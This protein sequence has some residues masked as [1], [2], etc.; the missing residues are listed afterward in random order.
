MQ[1]S[2]LKAL[3][4]E[5]KYEGG[6]SNHPRDPG[7]VTLEGIIQ[8]VYDAYR[9]RK[10][11]PTRPLTPQMR[12]TAEWTAERNDIYRAQYWN[13]IRGDELPAGIDLVVFDGAINSGPYQSVKWLQ[14]A[15]GVEATGNIGEVTLAALEMHPDHDKLI[16]DICA[17]RLGMLQNL[18]TWSTFGDGWS[19]RIASAKK[20]GQA[21]ASGSV[22]PAPVEAHV[23]RGDAKAY[24]S[25]IEQP[26]VD[27]QTAG[28][29]AV[30]SGGFAGLIN[31]T[32][33]QL[34]PFVGSSDFINKV[35]LG[36]T[37]LAVAIAIGGTIYMFWSSRKSKRARQAI[38]G[39]LTAEV[40]EGQP[41]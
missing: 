1:E 22:G 29:T 17:R 24:A 38:D 10:G 37:I 13:A 3:P 25:D 33:D 23:E 19:K 31:G 15:L 27:A 36:L 34:A 2:F 20:I 5:L 28:N 40:P 4:I 35:Y 12:G 14:R 8:R 16:A 30:G 32:K 21:W 11:L 26:A 9:K 41:A 7:G 6:F 39:E 18:S